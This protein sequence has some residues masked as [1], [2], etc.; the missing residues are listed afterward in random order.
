MTGQIPPETGEP[1]AAARGA[2]LFSD[3]D[4]A[5]DR[6]AGTAPARLPLETLV[7]QAPGEHGQPR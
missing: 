6:P 4:A 3:A 7:W 1:D 2:A 5:T